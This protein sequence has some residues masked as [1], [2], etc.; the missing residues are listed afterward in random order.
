MI[1]KWLVIIRGPTGVGKTKACEALGKL[2]HLS[3]DCMINL[4]N[5][6]RNLESK[7]RCQHVIAEVFSGGENTEEPLRWVRV[8]T[9]GGYR[10]L[11]VVLNANL[12]VVL[13]RNREDA[14]R[15]KRSEDCLIRLYQRF[16]SERKFR[17]FAKAARIDEICINA[18]KL[19][20]HCVAK[21]IHEEL[22]RRS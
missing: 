6:A 19:P 3:Y 16:Y 13:K 15:P 12:N 10:G 8:F 1:S 20:P 14:E 18:N 4:D 9:R 5:P 22:L 17:D 11:S 21:E 2:L 7:L